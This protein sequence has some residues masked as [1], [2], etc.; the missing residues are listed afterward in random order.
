MRNV[1]KSYPCVWRTQCLFVC[2]I[3]T[4]NLNN[5]YVYMSFLYTMFWCENVL[6][7]N[8]CIFLCIVSPSHHSHGA[9]SICKLCCVKVWCKSIHY[10]L[11]CIDCSYTTFLRKRGSVCGEKFSKSKYL[12]IF[13]DI[14]V[15]WSCIIRFLDEHSVCGTLFPAM[16]GSRELPTIIH[17]G[18]SLPTGMHRVG[19]LSSLFLSHYLI[20]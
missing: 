13:T 10:W 4:C 2:I 18:I 19:V 12:Y 17:C 16:P 14:L 11:N 5:M 8:A 7:C 3:I 1:C 15:L 20:I 6:F 9:T